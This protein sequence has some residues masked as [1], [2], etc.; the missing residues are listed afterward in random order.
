[1]NRSCHKDNKPASPSQMP[2]Y[3]VQIK[4][5]AEAIAKRNLLRQ[6]LNVFAPFED[7]TTRK[8]NKLVEVRRP[9]FSG[10]LFVRFDSQF[11][12]W[13]TVNST[14][15]VNRLVFFQRTIRHKFHRN[16]C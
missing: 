5:N 8:A 11:V 1:M 6:G 10:Y 3:V 12:R 4:P 7:V 16:L 9:L 15:G 2:W 14:V 13:R